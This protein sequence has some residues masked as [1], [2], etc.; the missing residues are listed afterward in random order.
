MSAKS[1][2]KSVWANDGVRRVVH[3]FWQAAAGS[4]VAG[5]FAAKS[6]SDVKL[7]IATSV[8]VG[9]AAVKAALLSK[10]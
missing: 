4:L 8:A 7:T 9:L 3:T 2:L 10:S 6:T 1:L 5:L